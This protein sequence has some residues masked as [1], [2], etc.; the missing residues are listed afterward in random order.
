MNKKQ[1]KKSML[2]M[3]CDFGVWRSNLAP[4][5]ILLVLKPIFNFP[6][7][8]TLNIC[9]QGS[10]QFSFEGQIL[11]ILK[12]QQKK[13]AFVSCIPSLHQ[14]LFHKLKTLK[15]KKIS[16]G[17]T[18]CHLSNIWKVQMHKFNPLSGPYPFHRI[19]HNRRSLRTLESINQ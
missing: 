5:Y 16:K 1:L 8:N 18:N 4:V 17:F 9:P 6:R 15:V 11:L 7:K 19:W 12:V 10:C 13:T 14:S 2:V 3:C